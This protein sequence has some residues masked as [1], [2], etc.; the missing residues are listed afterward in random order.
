MENTHTNVKPVASPVVNECMV[1]D[2]NFAAYPPFILNGLYDEPK[3]RADRLH[4][5]MHQ[6]LDNCG[7]AGIVQ[8]TEI[9]S[10]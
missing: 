5:F 2:F 8:T 3:C 1:L 7:F 9:A 10:A 6:F 4:I